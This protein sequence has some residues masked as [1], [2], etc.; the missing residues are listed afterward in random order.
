MNLLTAYRPIVGS[1]SVDRVRRKADAVRGRA[2]T[3]LNATKN[4]GGVAA[5]LKSFVPLMR[6]AG[7]DVRWGALDPPPGFFDVTKKIHN[8]L[9]GAPLAIRQR[10]WDLYH[11]GAATT[12]T[13]FVDEV[14][15][16][17]IHDPQPLPSAR[18]GAGSGS[19][20]WCCH[21]D[22][23][24]P[25]RTT[26]DRLGGYLRDMDACVY[27]VPAYRQRINPREEVIAPAIDPFSEKNVDLELAEAD[28]ILDA[29]GIPLD[30]PLV[31][32]VSRF[33]RAKDPLGVIRA[34][35]LARETVDFRLVLLG[36][37]AAD[38]P[39]GDE[40]RAEVLEKADDRTLVVDDPGDPRLVNA[41][42]RR[43]Q[44]VLQKSVQEGFGLT[45][46]EAMWKGTPVIGS[47]VGGIPTQIED[48]INGYLV[49]SAEAAARR[50]VELLEAPDLRRRMGEA[51][52]ASVRRR[53]LMIRY[54]EDWLD[55]L[56]SLEEVS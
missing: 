21:V 18:R 51:A 13:S 19:R 17:V 53:F 15:H 54:L 34:A 8:A 50:V 5:L 40:V 10:E 22:L 3:H 43:A 2:V 48:G 24:R 7:F 1:A 49:D 20:I 55:L 30:L 33:D 52:H 32:Q 26:L 42:Q 38:D 27:S 14:D 28:A 47:A 36:N 12:C 23:S 9:Q 56:L 39:E 31:A 37:L 46:A 29:Y 45:V 4:G 6:E 35:N 44:V 11:Q 25:D 16:L 41:L